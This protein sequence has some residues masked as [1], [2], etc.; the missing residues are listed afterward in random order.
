MDGF[1]IHCVFLHLL[2]LD[3]FIVVDQRFVEV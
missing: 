1:K 2:P 3:F